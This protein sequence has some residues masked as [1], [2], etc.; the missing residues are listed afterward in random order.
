MVTIVL[1]RQFK[2]Q[3]ISYCLSNI[4]KFLLIDIG[5]Q[6]ALVD[7]QKMT[8]GQNDLFE[9]YQILIYADWAEL[10]RKNDVLDLGKN[11]SNYSNRFNP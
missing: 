8:V 7:L 10:R 6:K 11:L 2:V 1:V 5:L 3:T 4:C 9:W